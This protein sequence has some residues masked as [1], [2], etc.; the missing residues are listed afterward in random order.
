MVYRVVLLSVISLLISS[1]V[2]RGQGQTAS[3]AQAL[4]LAAQSIAALTGQ[5]SISDATLTGNASW[6]KGNAYE[7]ATTATVS[8]AARG[9]TESRVEVRLD[10]GS[11]IEIRHGLSGAPQGK[12]SNPDSSSGY[13]A[14]HNCWSDAVWFFPPLSS[15]AKFANS[16]FVFSYVGKETWNDLDVVHLQVHQESVF[17]EQSHLSAMDFYLDPTTLFPLGVAFKTHPDKDMTRDISTEIQFADY[18]PVEGIYVPFH[19]KRLQSGALVLDIK[20]TGV[21][22]NSGVLENLFS[23]E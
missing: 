11:R 14:G 20:L 8:L 4:A 22:F 7:T 10:S 23:I 15:L 3:D 12:W 21:T 6:L 19:I 1:S 9:T 17:A 2:A 18:R 13:Y 16:S 5:T